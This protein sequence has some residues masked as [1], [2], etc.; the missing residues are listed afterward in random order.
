MTATGRILLLDYPYAETAIEE[1][2]LAPRTTVRGHGDDI[3]AVAAESGEAAPS[4]DDIEGLL[5]DMAR[6]DAALLDALPALRAVSVIG[7]GLDQIDLAAAEARGIAVR[8]VPTGSVEDVATHTVALAL[9]IWRR[10][11]VFHAHV[12][13]GG[14]DFLAAGPIDSLAAQTVG[15]VGFG[16]IGQATARRLQAFG[17]RVVA[18]SRSAAPAYAELG[19]ER[20]ELEELLGAS[21]LLISTAPL[22]DSTRDLLDEAKLRLLPRGAVVVS[23]G[24][25]RVLDTAAVARL[26]A[27][28]HLAG[29]ALDVFRNEPPHADELALLTASPNVILTPHAGFYAVDTDI[30]IRRAAC[31]HLLAELGSTTA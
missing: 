11:P 24:R 25:G 14:F 8:N 21:S 13:G 31:A 2:A 9:S 4:L 7:I 16:R 29:A 15:L 3:R 22:N 6:V 1:E 12:A 17:C 26:L 28:G 30:A 18:T 19:V 23:T 27:E 5:V 20:L 10:L